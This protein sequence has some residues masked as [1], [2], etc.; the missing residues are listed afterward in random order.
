MSLNQTQI[1]QEL[2]L[3]PGLEKQESLEIPVPIPVSCPEPVECGQEKQE[4]QEIPVKTHLGVLREEG[5]EEEPL[6]L[7]GGS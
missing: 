4:C 5:A 2:T 6:R 7:V 3:P 1:K